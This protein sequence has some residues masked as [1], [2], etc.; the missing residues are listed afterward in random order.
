[1]IT[2]EQIEEW[3]REVEQRP[4]SAALIIQAIGKRLAELTER[5]EELLADN[6]QLR[7]GQKTEDYEKRLAALEYQL[8]ILRRQIGQ[9]GGLSTETTIPDTVSLALFTR[10]GRVARVEVAISRLGAGMVLAALQPDEQG[11]IQHPRLLVTTP[12]EE[13][14]FVFDSGRTETHPVSAIPV[15]PEGDIALKRSWLVEPRGNEELSAVFP[16]SRMA[17]ANTCVQVSR[18]GCAKRM[19]RSSFEGHVGNNFIG[20]GVKTKLDRP[21]CLLF[22]EKGSRLILATSE[23]Y[24]VN[25]A[26]DDLPYSADEV[27]RLGITDHLVAAFLADEEKP[28]I[29]ITNNGKALEREADWLAPAESFRG[30]GQAVFSP[31]RRDA[32]IRIA[33]AACAAKTDWAALLLDDGRV[34]AY[35]IAD[36]AGSGAVPGVSDSISVLEYTNFSI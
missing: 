20:S 9:T 12:E 24:L 27:M 34:L 17:L 32:G 6:I 4:S 1:M 30:K 8:E 14:L 22:A 31:A 13:L 18:R 35:S 3:I 36:L 16:I 21:C 5:N 7:S 2:P 25:L 28:L 19:M 11:E 15:S 26:V 29:V 23:G 10:Q 33:G